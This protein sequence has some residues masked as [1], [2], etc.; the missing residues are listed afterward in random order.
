MLL[1]ASGSCTPGSRG[2]TCSSARARRRRPA[3]ASTSGD[4]LGTGIAWRRGCSPRRTVTGDRAGRRP[5]SIAR[6]SGCSSTPPGPWGGPDVD[7]LGRSRGGCATKLHPRAEPLGKPLVV[8]LIEDERHER[9]EQPVLPAWRRYASCGATVGMEEIPALPSASPRPA[10]RSSILPRPGDAARRLATLVRGNLVRAAA[11]ARRTSHGSGSGSGTGALPRREDRGR[12]IGPAA[13]RRGE[14]RR[15]PHRCRDG[16][17]PH[18]R[19]GT[20]RGNRGRTRSPGRAQAR[21][22]SGH[23][24]RRRAAQAEG[25]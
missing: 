5:S 8:V 22:V 19:W 14:G 17:R 6:S 25:A 7:E 24:E 12:A 20:D 1:V 9:H 18:P 16:R 23:P 2:A 15:Q 3:A 11:E 4:S 21:P 10:T 13:Q